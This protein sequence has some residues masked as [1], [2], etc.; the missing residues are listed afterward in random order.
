MKICRFCKKT[1]CS[2][3]LIENA[4]FPPFGS[5]IAEISSNSKEGRFGVTLG[6]LRAYRRRISCVM[7]VA[8]SHR[9]RLKTFKAGGDTGP[10]KARMV[11]IWRM[12][13]F[14]GAYRA[15]IYRMPA[16]YD[17]HP[18]PHHPTPTT[19]IC[20]RLNWSLSPLYRT[21]RGETERPLSESGHNKSF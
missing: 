20:V 7:H 11:R 4:R 16:V 17:A 18:T 12:D 2:R 6:P 5:D 19:T 21:R 13:S 3:I 8:T 10:R 15:L 1:Y 9:F 14:T